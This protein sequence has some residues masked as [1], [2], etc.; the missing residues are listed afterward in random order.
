MISFLVLS[1]QNSKLTL[2]KLHMKIMQIKE[3]LEYSM[4]PFKIKLHC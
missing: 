1:F 3:I 4:Q 2:V